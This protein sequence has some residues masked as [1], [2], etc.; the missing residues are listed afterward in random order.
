MVIST[1]CV[2]GADVKQVPIY[3]SSA[4]EDNYHRMINGGQQPLIRLKVN[5]Q[6]YN[7]IVDP[8]HHIHLIPIRR[9]PATGMMTESQPI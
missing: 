8:Q 6:V 2:D 1:N 9:V 3:Q 7:G 5:E 4:H